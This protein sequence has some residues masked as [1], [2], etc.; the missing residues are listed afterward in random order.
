MPRSASWGVIAACLALGLDAQGSGLVI[1]EF[2][3]ANRSG[4]TDAFGETSDWIEIQ[5]LTSVSTNLAGWHLTD[6]NDALTKWT[7]P[8][9]NIAANGYLLVFASG[10]DTPVVS[11]QLHAN[12]QLDADGEYLALV[13][14]DGVTVEYAYA[15]EFPPQSDDISY[16]LLADRVSFGF[17]STPTPIIESRT[18]STLALKYSW[19]RPSRTTCSGNSAFDALR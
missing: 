13:R 15:P 18:L 9:A 12:F 6:K 10:R 17:F 11:G 7:F 8:S 2:L 1:N 19:L 4:L 5:N 3:A 14:P 16:G